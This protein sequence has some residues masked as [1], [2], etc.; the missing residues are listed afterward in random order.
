M[1]ST[2]K[3]HILRVGTRGSRLALA[4]ARL[5]LD[6]LKR[7]APGLKFKLV[8]IQ[9]AG[10]KLAEVAPAELL[11]GSGKGLFVKEIEGA[12]LSGRVDL[13]IHS[14]KDM[15]GDITSGL[16]L[17][18]Y[19]K[20][21]DPRDALISQNGKGWEALPRKA[22]VGTSSP[23]RKCQFQELARRAGL[24]VEVVDL[25]GNLDT[26]VRK[27]ESAQVDGII[28]SAA[29]LF[30]LGM[31]KSASHLFDPVLEMVPACGQGALV[32][33]IR[34]DR[35]DLLK[36][37]GK[38]E[39]HKTRLSCELERLA[40]KT[41]GGGCLQAIGIF[42]RPPQDGMEADRDGALEL[43]IYHNAAADARPTSSAPPAPP[44]DGFH[45]SILIKAENAQTL[46]N[47]LAG[48]FHHGS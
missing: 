31:E 23:R 2:T 39:D 1:P 6:E 11:A 5:Y 18:G 43:H 25:R 16:I 14:L 29:G 36:L 12:L 3:R 35:A 30:R 45:S 9:T 41:M 37:L 10:D 20:R 33:E 8:E 27:V 40:L 7:K 22:R 17:C 4:Q 48:S 28:V 26:R 44:Q 38:A 24:D 13:A 15:P 46:V 42:A 21:G 34:E 47:K 32:A 19:Q